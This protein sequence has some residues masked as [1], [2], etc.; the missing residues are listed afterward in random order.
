MSEPT[1][2]NQTA[3]VINSAIKAAIDG[4]SRAVE[5]A[6]ITD[7][8]WLGL[9]VVKQLLEYALGFFENYL[10]T[11]A[12]NAATSIVIDLQTSQEKS[13]TK[14]AFQGVIDAVQTGDQGVIQKASDALDNAFAKLIHSD[15]SATP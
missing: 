15:G 11:N 7:V 3:T 10:Y 13:A 4:G 5:A 9:P 14:A 1:P 12:A 8:P 2:I 6:I